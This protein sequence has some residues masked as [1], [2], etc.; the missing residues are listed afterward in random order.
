MCFESF[1]FSVLIGN[2]PHGPVRI[3]NLEGQ[4]SLAVTEL[5]NHNTIRYRFL[6]FDI[7]ITGVVFC[8]RVDDILRQVVVHEVI[9]LLEIVGPFFVIFG[10]VSDAADQ[11]RP[12]PMVEDEVI[13]TLMAYDWPGNVRELKNEINRIM[14]F[15]PRKRGRSPRITMDMLSPVLR[16]S[17]VISDGEM[18]F[19]QAQDH[20]GR[21]FISRTLA[22]HGGNQTKAAKVLGFSRSGLIKRMRKLGMLNRE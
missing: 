8:Q 15:L 17:G 18:T 2:I 13:Q 4:V 12:V 10:T 7:F 1:D 19:A 3:P 5:I 22:R 16:S 9:D 11:K 14:T 20:F 21:V 6:W